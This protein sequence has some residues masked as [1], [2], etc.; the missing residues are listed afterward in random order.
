MILYR[1]FAREVFG[2]MFAVAGIV[3]VISMGWRFSGYLRDAARGLLT[4]DILFLIMAYRLPG[5]LELIIPISFF[6]AIML[7]YGR[8]YV[9]SEMV[10]LQSCG[11]SPAK[12][13]GIT[14]TLAA[15]VMLLT[16]V[17]SLWL[18]PAGEAEVE[19]LFANQQSLTEFDTLAPGRFQNLRSGERVTYTESLSDEGVLQNV[20]INEY[21]DG[22]VYGA[23][24]VITVA[25]E[26]GTAQVDANGNRF[27]VLHDGT[28]FN[29][30][31]GNL[32]Y[33][34]IEYE[35]YGQLIEKEADKTPYRRRSAIPTSELLEL[36]NPQQ[37]SE[38]QWRISIILLI[39][40]IAV[41][42]IPLSRV[43]PR[44]GRFTRLVP[45]MLLSFIYVISLSAARAAVEKQQ[46]STDVGLW[47][48]HGIFVAIAFLLFHLHW[49]EKP[50]DA[51]AA[52]ATAGRA[53]N[54]DA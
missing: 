40:V 20:F 14:L 52:W 25:A 43:N 30:K 17:I 37:I 47:W 10:V 38:L 16:A 24:D 54:E 44:Q 26:T 51:V 39:P 48:V 3:L 5:F 15:F 7:A 34:V 23:K 35:E 19:R 2:T 29:G 32:N 41:M 21:K 22:N 31:P 50:I 13:M 8:F 12:L 18:K 6:L 1:Y 53:S 45:G 4:Q 33:R 36:K 46:L 49:L 11:V 9:D 42:A 28:R 27:L